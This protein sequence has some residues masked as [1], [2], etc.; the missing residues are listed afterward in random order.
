MYTD[1]ELKDIAV[2]ILLKIEKNFDFEETEVFIQSLSQLTGGIEYRIPKEYQSVNRVGCA[3]R[4]FKD[5]K[6]FF[7]CFPLSTVLKEIEILEKI[8]TFPIHT[9][10]FSFPQI[11]L[12]SSSVSK[13]YDKRIAAL[14]EEEML[15]LASV[16]SET[17]QKIKDIILDGTIIFSLERKVIANSSQTIAFEKSTWN[18]IF[19]RVLYRGYDI[20]STS[21]KHLISRQIPQSLDSTVESLVNES[22]QRSVVKDIVKSENPRVIFSPM[23]FSQIFSFSFIPL[24]RIQNRKRLEQLELS[25]KFTLI[26][27]GTIPGLPNSTAFDDEGVAQSKTV[28]VEKGEVISSLNNTQNQLKEGEKTGNSFRIDMFNYFPRTYKAYPE[29]YPSN[30]LIGEG[31][32]P[33]EQMITDIKEGILIN[34]TQGYMTADPF[35]GTFKISANN[36]YQ[37]KKGE[38]SGSLSSFDVLGSIFE[39][40]SSEMTISKERSVVRPG[41]TPYSILSPYFTTERV[42]IFI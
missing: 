5:G 10:K 26:D 30:L 20:I 22:I 24:L 38:I 13:I 40:L 39:I 25:K 33:F 1:E 37:I 21:E 2:Q 12:T 17:E 19:L 11:S 35:S 32:V 7:A 41:N 18:D 9:N 6:L 29:I 27:D 42:S 4:F 36:A 31:S 28:L 16:I 23:A 34:S 3:L 8:T 15:N 14:N